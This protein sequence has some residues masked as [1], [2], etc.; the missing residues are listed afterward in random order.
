MTNN[1]SLSALLKLLRAHGC[2]SYKHDG[3]EL[4][5]DPHF[6]PVTKTA[7]KIDST[8]SPLS[9]QAQVDGVAPGFLGMSPE[10]VLFYSS[11]GKP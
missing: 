9:L 4:L 2:V 6:T 3:L 11:G 1:R 5:L 10:E 8:G 7:S